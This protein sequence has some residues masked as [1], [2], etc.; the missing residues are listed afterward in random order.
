MLTTPLNL[1]VDTK[2]KWS[3]TTKNSDNVQVVIAQCTRSS[4]NAAKFDLWVINELY[5]RKDVHLPWL[6]FLLLGNGRLVIYDTS[7]DSYTL[8][9]I[10]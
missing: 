5:G 7:S 1:K 4:I 8:A 2:W 9:N 6:W 10:L 3:E